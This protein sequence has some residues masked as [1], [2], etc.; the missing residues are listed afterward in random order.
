MSAPSVG[1]RYTSYCYEVLY[2]LGWDWFDVWVRWVLSGWLTSGNK[3]L[4]SAT[5]AGR[6]QGRLTVNP[7]EEAS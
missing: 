5:S 4:D 7:L 2:L 3:G 6:M 1:S